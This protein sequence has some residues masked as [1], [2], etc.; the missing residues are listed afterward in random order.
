MTPYQLSYLHREVK[1]QDPILVHD[2]RECISLKS[3]TCVYC[4]CEI[5]KGD[6]YFSYKPIFGKRKARCIDHPPR[7]YNDVE[8]YDI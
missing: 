4:G 5:P 2:V 1:K 3:R 8:R 6:R 7:I